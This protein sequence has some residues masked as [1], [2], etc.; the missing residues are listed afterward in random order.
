[1]RQIDIKA[2]IIKSLQN[3][4]NDKLEDVWN[5]IDHLEEENS[6]KKKLLSFA[7]TWKDIDDSLFEDLTV[8]LINRRRTGSSKRAK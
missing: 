2:K 6:N 8:N 4:S 7:G 5:Y 1:M 3:F